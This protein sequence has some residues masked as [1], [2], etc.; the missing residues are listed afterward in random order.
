M[1]HFFAFVLVVLPTTLI[2]A[3]TNTPIALSTHSTIYQSD[4]SSASAFFDIKAK[5][6]IVVYGLDVNIA[7][8][9]SHSVTVYTKSGSYNTNNAVYD[10]SS[11]TMIL[12]STAI[13]GQ[14]MNTPTVILTENWNPVL[15]PKGTK[16]SFMISFDSGIVRSKTYNTDNNERM[17]YINHDVI[18]YGKGASKRKGWD[19]RL[20]D[21]NT[22]FSGGV[23]YS[24]GE[25]SLEVVAGNIVGLPTVAPTVS[26]SPTDFPTTTP[27]AS[28]VNPTNSPSMS[29]TVTPS[30]SL[31][32][33]SMPS[34]SPSESPSTSLQPSNSPTPAPTTSPTSSPSNS[35]TPKPTSH[36]TLSPQSNTNAFV[37]TFNSEV[38]FS[39]LMYDIVAK[40]DIEIKGFGFN[41]YWTDEVYVEV[42]TTQGSYVDKET[43]RKAWRLVLN[44]T[45]IG[46]GL[47]RITTIP[48]DSFDRIK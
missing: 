46:A 27:S 21:G 18:I 9:S 32:P 5:K 34:Q 13:T 16:Q 47:D 37:S 26:R 4:V 20:I 14:G 17:Y 22:V 24:V 48:S 29:P 3:A 44:T 39:G 28:P 8:T 10:E 42:W 35:P 11:W 40:K 43:K 7:S 25:E 31:I 33:T 45:V 15:I 12:N 41:T 23:K 38:T 30:T 1:K 6:S 19:G 36:P 2:H